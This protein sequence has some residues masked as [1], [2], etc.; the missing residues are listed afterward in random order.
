M[1]QGVHKLKQ[2]GFKLA[3]PKA[4]R[5][6]LRPPK[7]SGTPQVAGTFSKPEKPFTNLYSILFESNDL[8]YESSPSLIL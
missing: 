8:K 3:D 2:T 4:N 1:V 6:R 7:P 5:L